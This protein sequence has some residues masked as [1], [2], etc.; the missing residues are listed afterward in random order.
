MCLVIVIHVKN[1][2]QDKPTGLTVQT[3]LPLHGNISIMLAFNNICIS[4]IGAGFF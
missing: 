1:I 2:N 3:V 4:P